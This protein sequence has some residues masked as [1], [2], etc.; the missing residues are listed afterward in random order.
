MRNLSPQNL[1][2]KQ[3]IPLMSGEKGRYTR[4]HSG[5]ICNIECEV[6]QVAVKLGVYLALGVDYLK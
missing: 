5:V 3:S 2:G 6:A 1:L 4:N